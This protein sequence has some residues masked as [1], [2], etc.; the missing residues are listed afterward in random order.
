VTCSTT[1]DV[2]VTLG[3]PGTLDNPLAS[4]TFPFGCTSVDFTSS[5]DVGRNDPSVDDEEAWT[6][7]VVF[8]GDPGS[9]QILFQTIEW[10]AEEAD[11]Q[12]GSLVVPTTQVALTLGGTPQPVVFCSTRTGEL[13]DSEIGQC[14]DYR[15]IVENGPVP[16][17][18]GDIQLTEYFKLRGD[19][20]SYR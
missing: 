2:V 16:P 9:N 3:Q 15:T 18:P 11:Y 1:E 20:S 7:F 12:N 5:F 8:S 4:V 19:P 6:Q 17:L 14:L 13:P 10:D